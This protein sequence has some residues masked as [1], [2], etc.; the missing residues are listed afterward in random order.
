MRYLPMWLFSQNDQEKL[1]PFDA[2][3]DSLNLYSIL[4]RLRIFFFIKNHQG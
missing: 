4:L 2:Q 1:N 3:S